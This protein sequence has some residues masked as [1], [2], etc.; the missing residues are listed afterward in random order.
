MHALGILLAVLPGA[1]QAAPNGP[2]EIDSDRGSL[3]VTQSAAA[4]WPSPAGAPA[5]KPELVLRCA[6]GEKEAYLYFA[7]GFPSKQ[8]DLFVRFEGDTAKPTKYWGA[9]SHDGRS[10]F[11][12][13]F[14]TK[15][16]D[17]F[18]K[19]LL[20]AKSRTVAI[21]V[22]PKKKDPLPEARFH[23]A[24]LETALGEWLRECPLQK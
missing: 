9:P 3:I 19:S 21:T 16:T 18:V 2:W 24:G 6:G 17:R 1:P 10:F 14:W 15:G 23:L 20:E 12:T 13:G 8:G 7:H 11:V 4:E 5:E 22:K